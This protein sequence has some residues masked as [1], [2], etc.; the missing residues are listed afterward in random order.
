MSS[1]IS[2]CRYLDVER[3]PRLDEEIDAIFFEASNTKSFESDA[4]RSAFRER[5]LRRYLRDDPQFAYLAMSIS[6]DV[7]GYLVGTI[8]DPAS[9]RSMENATSAFHEATKR[10]PAHLHV[11][12]APAYRSSGV[13]GSLIDTFVA[14]ARRAGAAGVHVITSAASANVRFYNRNGFQEIAR[15]GP[16]DALVFLARA[17]A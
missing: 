2:I 6:G 13:G 17:L 16:A 8:E 5:W 12:V 9:S 1:H 15:S 4:A 3:T 11:N 10:Y 7:V 14:D